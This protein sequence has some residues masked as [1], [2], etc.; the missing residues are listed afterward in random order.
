MSGPK[1]SQTALYEVLVSE[2][3]SLK[4]TKREYDKVLSQVN[5]H[6]IR[7]EEIYKKPISVDTEEMRL[8]H[9]RIKSTLDRALYFPKWLVIS[10]LIFIV[11]F[12][13]SIFFN[14]KQYFTNKKQRN[15]IQAADSYIEELEAQIPKY[16]NKR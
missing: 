5:I 8:E 14:Y 2:V 10:F 12:F 9:E 6:L 16:K 11:V 3:E 13:T 7:L 1:L 4:T 15:Y